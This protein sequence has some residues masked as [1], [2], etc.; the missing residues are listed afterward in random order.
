L[1]ER[2]V[3]KLL[4][5]L[6]K[7]NHHFSKFKNWFLIDDDIIFIGFILLSHS[8]LLELEFVLKNNFSQTN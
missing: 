7:W 1:S 3:F 4:E 6:S 5:G 2:F 8:M